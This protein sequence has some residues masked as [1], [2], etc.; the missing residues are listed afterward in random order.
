WPEYVASLMQPLPVVYC[1]VSGFQLCAD[2]KAYQSLISPRMKGIRSSERNLLT[3]RGSGTSISIRNRES[4]EGFPLKLLAVESDQRCGQPFLRQGPE[5]SKSGSSR[6]QRERR[7][8][9]PQTS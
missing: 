5:S 6:S 3:Q 2:L 7:S 1:S 8:R 4:K 9:Q